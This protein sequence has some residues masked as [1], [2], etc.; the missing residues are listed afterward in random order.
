[1]QAH[2]IRLVQDATEVAGEFEL[3]IQDESRALAAGDVV[4]WHEPGPPYR[5]WHGVVVGQDHD[6]ELKVSIPG[7][8]RVVRARPDRLHR[9]PL[10]LLESC[11]FCRVRHLIA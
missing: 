7:Q 11:R 2:N 5:L 6:G 4:F 1:V 8:G 9:E 3:I 10:D